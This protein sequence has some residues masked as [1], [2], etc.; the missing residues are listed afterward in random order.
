MPVLL[1]VALVALGVYLLTKTDP[2]TVQTTDTSG[3]LVPTTEPSIIVNMPVDV[4]SY[5]VDAAIKYGVDRNIVLAQAYAESQG[6]QNAVSPVGAI[7]VMQ[8]MPATA[9]DLGVDPYDVVQNIDGGVRYLASQVSRFGNYALALAAYN[10]G[11]GRV[12]THQDPS[13][14]PAETQQY[15][16]KIMR[17]VGLA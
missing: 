10:W 6:N 15:V 11:P 16:S 14:W 2:S 4:V 7:G 12:L 8:L 13:Q 1:L 5:L 9:A 3:T 17:W